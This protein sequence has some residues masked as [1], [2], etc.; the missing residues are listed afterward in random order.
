MLHVPACIIRSIS[1]YLLS[2]HHVPGTHCSRHKTQSLPSWSTY[3]N[4][5]AHKK[6]R[7]KYRCQKVTH[8]TYPC[9]LVHKRDHTIHDSLSCSFFSLL[10]IKCAFTLQ[11]IMIFVNFFDHQGNLEQH[12]EAAFSSLYCESFWQKA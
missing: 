7:I 4:R 12:A 2:A 1:N 6:G 11:Y 10:Y 5:G 3:S 9:T 8:H